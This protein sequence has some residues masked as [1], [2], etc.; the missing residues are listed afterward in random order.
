MSKK[1]KEA[2]KAQRQSL[3]TP[4]ENTQVKEEQEVQDKLKMKLI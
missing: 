2:R 4:E 3:Y 1:H